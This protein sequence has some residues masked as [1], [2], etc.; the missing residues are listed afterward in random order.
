M[1]PQAQKAWGCPWCLWF[2]MFNS[3]HHEIIAKDF[4]LQIMLFTLYTWENSK[5][6]WA[7]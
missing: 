4:V 3:I 6:K 1:S 5:Y 7:L 2:P